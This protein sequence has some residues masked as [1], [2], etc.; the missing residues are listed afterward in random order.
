MRRLTHPIT[1]WTYEWADNGVGPVLVTDRDGVQ[2]HFDRDGCAVKGE[3][4][5]AD[6]EMCRWIGSGGPTPGGSSGRS[7]RF[8]VPTPAQAAEPTADS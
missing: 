6:P 1:G 8:A 2:G 5:W 7:R 4:L 3:L